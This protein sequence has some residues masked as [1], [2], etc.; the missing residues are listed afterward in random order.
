MIHR[1][2]PGR[3]LAVTSLAS[4]AA[5]GASLLPATG[6]SQAAYNVGV[7]SLTF[8]SVAD[9]C[10]DGQALPCTLGA[11]SGES[12]VVRVT[13][14]PVDGHYQ[15]N[16]LEGTSTLDDTLWVSAEIGAKCRAAHHLLRASIDDQLGNTDLDGPTTAL[17]PFGLS[18]DTFGFPSVVDVPDAREMPAKRVAINVPIDTAF[19]PA[20]PLVGFFP[21]PQDVFDAGEAEIQR[22]IDDGMSPA[23]ARG[24]PW[25]LNTTITL[26]AQAVCEYNGVI[27]AAYYKAKFLSIPLRIDYLPVDVPTPVGE[28]PPPV[29]DVVKPAEV[30]DASLAVVPDPADPCT[31]N[32]SATISTD[33]ETD[34]TYR[35]VNPYGQSS[36]TYSVHVDETHVAMV[37]RTV[38]VPHHDG[39]DPDGDLAPTPGGRGDIDDLAVESTDQYTGTYELEVLSPN[40]VTAVDGFSVDYC[41]E[42][43]RPNPAIDP[44][45]GDVVA[46]PDP[47]HSGSTPSAPV[48]P[49]PDSTVPTTM[50][51]DPTVPTTPAPDG[52]LTTPIIVVGGASNG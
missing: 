47:T 1:S 2:I 14:S 42:V 40:H 16:D 4:V 8:N 50:A 24:T 36:N 22:R 39:V 21:T 30:V 11:G 29:D 28:L 41:T 38:E 27:A 13:Q 5:A 9:A 51:P 32:L 25:A 45:V 17:N 26:R 18:D 19:D 48:P 20:N 33:G 15:F 31:L 10:T 43:T 35:F 37:N 12:N 3:A 44:P 23:E 46:D 34:V 52:T 6:T 7:Q 49:A